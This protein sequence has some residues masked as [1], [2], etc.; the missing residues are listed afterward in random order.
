M[1]LKLTRVF[2]VFVVI[3]FLLEHFNIVTFNYLFIF[4][5]FTSWIHWMNIIYKQKIWFISQNFQW[6]LLKLS[7]KW[8][9]IVRHQ[10]CC[11][12]D[13]SDKRWLEFIITYPFDS[14]FCERLKIS[15]VK[16]W[17]MLDI[18][19]FWCRFFEEKNLGI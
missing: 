15:F 17:I 1:T 14:E 4:T 10:C 3:W 6:K 16:R 13:I 12:L 8:V 18:L 19:K 5:F 2:L 11:R 7:L 9:T